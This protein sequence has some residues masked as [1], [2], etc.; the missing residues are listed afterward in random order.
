MGCPPRVDA[1][2]GREQACDRAGTRRA[3]TYDQQMH[4]YRDTR[5]ST[6]LV[7]NRGGSG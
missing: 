7:R 2:R 4:V 6:P 1:T 5:V 3:T